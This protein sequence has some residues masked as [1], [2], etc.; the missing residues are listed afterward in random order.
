MNKHTRFQKQ[1]ALS[2]ININIQQRYDRKTFDYCM[3]CKVNLYMFIE[4]FINYY[5]TKEVAC[6]VL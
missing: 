2:S 4:C 5:K 1:Q 3:K 6:K